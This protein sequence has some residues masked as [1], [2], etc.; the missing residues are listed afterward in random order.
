MIAPEAALVKVPEICFVSNPVDVQLVLSGIPDAS[1]LLRRLLDGGH[2]VIAGRL[3]GAFRRI[4]RGDVADE[5][6]TVM[7]RAGHDVQDSDPLK[8]AQAVRSASPDPGADRRSSALIPASALAGYRNGPVYLRGS[9]HVPP[10]WE[11]VRDGMPTL[12]DLLEA[13]AEP[14]V[15]AVLGHWLFG[16]IHPYADGNG[17]MARFVMNALLASGGY[18][19]TVIRVDDRDAYFAS[20]ERAS[21]DQDMEPFARFLAERVELA[22]ERAGV[23]S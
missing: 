15:K 22:L 10:R 21:I 17:R 16:Y 19:W 18:S 4:G 2:S 3:T 9:R 6:V 11:A 13:E 23:N 1:N 20:L 5:I 14:S 12:F 8:P 7:R